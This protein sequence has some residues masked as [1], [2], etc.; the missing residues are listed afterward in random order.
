MENVASRKWEMQ[1]ID[2]ARSLL[3]EI[4]LPEESMCSLIGYCDGS[5]VGYGCALYLRWFNKD[6]TVIDVTFLGAEGKMNPIKGTTVPR[7]EM[8]GAFTLSRL[9]YSA[10]NSLSKTEIGDLIQ[11]E[12]LFTDSTTVLSWIRSAA[13]KYKPFVKNKIVEIQ[14]LHPIEVWKYVLKY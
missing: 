6:E 14:E 3:P 8:C 12:I 10:R 4:E 11:E 9:A 1:W 2:C 5:S 7:S 13:I